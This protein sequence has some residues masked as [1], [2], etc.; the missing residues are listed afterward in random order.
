LQFIKLMVFGT[1]IYKKIPTY[2]VRPQKQLMTRQFDLQS[3]YIHLI[4][5]KV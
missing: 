1:S 5:A 2:L 3:I 4:A